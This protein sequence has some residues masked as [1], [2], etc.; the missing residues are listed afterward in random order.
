MG[1]LQ[2]QRQLSVQEAEAIGL[3]GVFQGLIGYG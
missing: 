3:K 2:A 1:A